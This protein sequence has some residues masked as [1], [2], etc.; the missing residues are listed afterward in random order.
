[1]TENELSKIV[2][3]CC[4]TIHKKLGPGMLESVYEEILYY[5]LKKH[6]VKCEKQVGL[7][8]TYEDIKLDIGFRADIVVEDKVILELKSVEKSCPFT[9][10]NF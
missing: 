7:P 3:D 10:S 6:H 2:V 8:V 1:M 9:K 5:E 4:L